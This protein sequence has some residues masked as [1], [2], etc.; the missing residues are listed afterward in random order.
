MRLFDE[1]PEAFRQPVISAGLP[2]VSIHP[3][4][5]DHPLPI[6]GYD[7]AMQVQV[8]PVLHR[9]TIELRNQPPGSRHPAALQPNPLPVGAQ[10]V[11]PMPRM[12]AAA[13][14]N[15]KSENG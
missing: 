10:P 1:A 4:L 12:L 11:R 2:A 9:G 6:V 8:A 15:V 13:A 7:E 14:A 5:N 3:L